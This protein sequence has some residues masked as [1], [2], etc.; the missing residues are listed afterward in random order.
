MIILPKVKSKAINL[1]MVRLC[2]KELDEVTFPINWGIFHTL[3]P[4]PTLHPCHLRSLF[5]K[6]PFKRLI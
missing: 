4:L 3:F 5:S 1:P 2:P 6:N